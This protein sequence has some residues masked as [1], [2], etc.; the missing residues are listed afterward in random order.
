MLQERSF[1]IHRHENLIIV[2]ATG[3][4][5]SYIAC[6]L[7]VE[8]CNAPLKVMY[9]RLPDLL[10]ELD[11]AKVQENYRK[12]INQYIKCDLLILDEWLLIGT[13]NAEQQDILEIL[14]KRYRTFQQY[15]ALSLMLQD[16]TVSLVEVA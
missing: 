3:S 7:G 2:G 10:A 6:A 5:K 11:F 15:S 13:N 9:V 12:R 16:D 14:E 1:Y 4:G 8:A